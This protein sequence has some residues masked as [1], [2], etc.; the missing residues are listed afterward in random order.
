[1]NDGTRTIYRVIQKGVGANIPVTDFESLVTHHPYDNRNAHME[2][3]VIVDGQ[4]RRMHAYA[5]GE[6]QEI[7]TARNGKSYGLK[8]DQVLLKKDFIIEHPDHPTMSAAS[9]RVD[10]PSPIAGY[11]GN[12]NAREGLV[13][14]HDK[15][16][17]D[18][19]AR[20]RHMRG[21]AV[22]EGQ[23][24]E[25]GQTLGTQSDVQ[26]GAK[27]VHMEIDTRYYQQYENYISD[28]VS[29][30]LPIEAD[31]RAD[32]RALPVM[33][34][35]TIRLGESNERVKDLQRVM[36]SEGYRS[37]NDGQIGRAHV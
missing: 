10:V 18:V 36:V 24:I 30:R 25:Y 6:I 3:G 13:D 34:D 9:R 11:I 16:G 31:Q 12:V 20:I 17:G 29:G 21:I 4:R 15:K 27:H 8:P 37:A 2:D 22:A 35:S 33:D 23:F 19:I 14:I 26:S 5:G 32:V 28:L 7:E 1:M